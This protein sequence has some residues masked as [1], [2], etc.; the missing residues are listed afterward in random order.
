M[1]NVA[2]WADANIQP[3]RMDGIDAGLDY[4]DTIALSRRTQLS[5]G[6][7]IGGYGSRNG[8]TQYR[9]NGN[10]TI[11]RG[12]GRTWSASAEYFRAT[13]FFALFREPVLTDSVSGSF[14]G[15]LAPRVRWNSGARWTRGQVGFGT[16]N[17]FYTYS[18]TSSLGV[19]ITR[20]LG[21]YAQY[22]Y[23]HND[24]GAASSTFTNFNILSNVAR[25]IVSTGLS[26]WL[27]IFNNERAP[28]D[29]N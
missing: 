11:S 17:V 9:L 5:F 22:G 23:Y 26:I 15:L 3:V 10:V 1:Q 21:A 6:S 27:P 14:G 8:P 13:Q 7:S 25:Q 16:T 20:L 29:S 24:L 19:A 28:R 4:G 18:A 12:I 2:Q